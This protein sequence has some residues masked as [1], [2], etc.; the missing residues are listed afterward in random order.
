MSYGHPAEL[1]WDIEETQCG[2][3]EFKNPHGTDGDHEYLM[4][5]EIE[6][7]MVLDGDWP[8]EIEEDEF[9]QAYCIKYRDETLAEESA[10]EQE[11]LF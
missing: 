4:C 10:P 3:C 2:T 8:D 5:P 6:I 7:P 9:G 1:A 11:Q